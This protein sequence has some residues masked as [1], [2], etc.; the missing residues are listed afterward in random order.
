[1]MVSLDGYIE[2][3]NHDLSWHNTDQEFNTFAAKQM[4]E[5]GAILLGHRTYN[6][7]HSYWP[8][9]TPTDPGDAIVAQVMNTLPKYVFSR[10]LKKVKEEQNWRN[11]HIIKDNIGETLAQLK[12]EEGKD[13]AVLGSNNACVTLLELGLLDEIRIM[14]NPIALGK[15]TPL[16]TGI[17]E[18]K[19]F[20]LTD[21]KRFLNGNVLLTY[22][23]NK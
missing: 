19:Q 3:E 1:M 16:F 21:T 20:T 9:A 18:K 14:I 5:M 13:I 4:Q 15:G 7:M 6:L 8:A 2:G 12:K 11:I 17:P 22:S 10:T 23:V